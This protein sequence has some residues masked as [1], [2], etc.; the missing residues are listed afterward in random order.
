MTTTQTDARQVVAELTRHHDLLVAE[1][2]E[3]TAAYVASPDAPAAKQAVVDWIH[4]KLIPHAAEEEQTSYAAAAAL[5]EGAALVR[6]MIGEHVT[7][8]AI[9]AELHRSEGALSAGFARSLY[10][11][12]LGH[13]S[14]E[15]DIVFPMLLDAPG[16]DLAQVMAEHSEGHGH[17][18]HHH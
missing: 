7:I 9:A 13:Q 5:P 3:L 14:K 10:L 17:A 12:F 6:A 18:H 11:A 1:L 8:K 16:V 2:D 4:E 15:N